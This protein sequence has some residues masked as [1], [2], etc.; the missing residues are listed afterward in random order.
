MT[1]AVAN[2]TPES[3]V[4]PQPRDIHSS[5]P[6]P[7]WQRGFWALIITQFQN[8]FNDNAI[9]FLVIYII[10]AMNFPKD[11]RENL[12]LARRCAVRSAIYLLFDGRRKS[13]R[14][15]Q[16]AER[17]DWHEADGNCCDG[18]G[19]CRP[20]DAQL[21]DRVHG[22]FPDQFS[23][24]ALRPFEIWFVAG[25]CSRAKAVVGERNY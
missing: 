15:I 11:E 12:M 9:K 16:Q 7:N 25:A 24:C 8:A 14:P 19:D 6:P 13:R 4:S 21:A 17:G 22:S 20:C 5:S 10:V 2:S 3:A 18:C 23:I 1:E